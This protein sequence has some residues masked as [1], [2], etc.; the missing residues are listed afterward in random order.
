[1]VTVSSPFSYITHLIAVVKR[2]G[3]DRNFPSESETN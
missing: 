2:S 3:F 1:M